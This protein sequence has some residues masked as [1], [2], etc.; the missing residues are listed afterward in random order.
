[1]CFIKNYNVRIE[2]LYLGLGL[3]AEGKTFNCKGFSATDAALTRFSLP[4]VPFKS[5]PLHLQTYQKLNLM[6]A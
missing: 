3:S 2:S 4:A 1:M 5:K 6:K